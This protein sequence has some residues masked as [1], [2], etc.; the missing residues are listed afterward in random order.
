MTSA[1]DVQ[2]ETLWQQAQQDLATQPIVLNPVTVEMHGGTLETVPADPRAYS[3]KPDCVAVIGVPDMT[4]AQL[5]AE[6]PG[7][8]TEH[9]VDPTGVIPAP[10]NAQTKY[11]VAYTTSGSIYVAASQVLNPG[12]TGWEMQNVILAR[13][14]YNTAGR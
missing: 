9:N 11:C 5:Q 1:T 14:G 4:V 2:L 13:L 7:L 12:A 3:V 6:N 10:G 8:A